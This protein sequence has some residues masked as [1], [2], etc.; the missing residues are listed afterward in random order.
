MCFRFTDER[1]KPAY[2]LPDQ[3]DK[4]AY[5]LMDKGTSDFFSSWPHFISTAPGVAYAY[6]D[7]YRRNR[8]DIF[9]TAPSLDALAGKRNMPAAA[10]GETVHKYSASAGNRPQ[11]GGGP[12]IALGPVRSVFVHSE[13]GLVVDRVHRVRGDDDRPIP[14]LY[15]AGSTG[16]GGLLLNGHG[17]HL[18]WAF[19]SRRRAGRNAVRDGPT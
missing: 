12:C 3:P 5:I 14:G 4:I 15:A 18:G 2:A 9:N 1:G 10:L 8:R 13:S 11:F 7:D 16:Q 6:V 19:T 17:H